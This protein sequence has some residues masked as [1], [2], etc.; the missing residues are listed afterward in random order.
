M[1][2]KDAG[3]AQSC[4]IDPLHQGNVRK[5]RFMRWSGHVTIIKSFERSEVKECFEGESPGLVVM[6]GDSCSKG[7]GFK[8]Q[9]KVLRVLRLVAIS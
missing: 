2:E 7:P 4:K 5:N 9:C 8:S 1:N 6:G 3:K